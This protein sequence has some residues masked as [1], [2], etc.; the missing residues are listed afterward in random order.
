[1]S[2]GQS[3]YLSCVAQLTMLPNIAAGPLPWLC[4]H[5]HPVQ[6][7]L[8]ALAHGIL[9]LGIIVQR[10]LLIEHLDM[11][12]QHSSNGEGQRCVQSQQHHDTH[13]AQHSTAR[14]CSQHT[15]LRR[16]CVCC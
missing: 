16:A 1:M 3:G 15:P 9:G 12:S 8:Q 6:L 14:I 2:C 11:N 4:S 7:V 13:R 5:L 10:G